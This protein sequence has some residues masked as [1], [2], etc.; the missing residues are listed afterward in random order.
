VQPIHIDDVVEVVLHMVEQLPSQHAGA[1]RVTLVGPEPL[2]MRA[3]I[4]KLRTALRLDRAR[5]IAIPMPLV[6]WA[7]AIA[8]HVSGSL[9]DRATLA[10]LERGNTAPV[11]DTHRWLG[12]A[13]RGVENFIVDDEVEAARTTAR[14][15]WLLPMLRVSIAIVWIVTGVVS[16]AIYPVSESYALLARVGIHGVLATWMLYGAAV[17]DIALGIGTLL[18]S[19]RRLLWLLQ[20]AV[21]VGYSIIITVKLPE[22]WAH[23][24]G[25]LL[26]NIPMLAAIWLLYELEER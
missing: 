22:F 14:L 2:T 17:L 6:R 20:I 26:K 23:P 25:P 15:S 19:R 24:Y 12:R 5:F 10:M 21:I 4:A 8:E 9:L 16:L 11:D 1:R 13:P 7:A 3:F 18:L